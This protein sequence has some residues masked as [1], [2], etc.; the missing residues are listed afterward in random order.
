MICS[1]VF[2]KVFVWACIS[3]WRSN[4]AEG[5][6][7]LSTRFWMAN[8]SEKCEVLWCQD[9]FK[10]KINCPAT[11]LLCNHQ[12]VTD[13]ECQPAM[14]EVF[15]KGFGVWKLRGM[16]VIFQRSFSLKLKN[17]TIYSGRVRTVFW[18]YFYIS[19]RKWIWDWKSHYSSSFWMLEVQCWWEREERE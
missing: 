5:G 13:Q 2:S 1:S 15:L 14:W 16:G 6:V 12:F 11:D 10:E 8:K 7:G 4:K 18:Y 9:Y 17:G 19:I 3:D